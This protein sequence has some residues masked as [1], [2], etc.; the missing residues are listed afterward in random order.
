M[1]SVTSFLTIASVSL[2]S[3]LTQQVSAQTYRNSVLYH[4][5][6]NGGSGLDVEDFSQSYQVPVVHTNSV[7]SPPNG[8]T[9]SSWLNLRI[10]SGYGVLSVSAQGSA[11]RVV[12]G[13]VGR[14]GAAKLLSTNDYLAKFQDRLT[15]GSNVLPPF[16]EVTLKVSITASGNVDF[17]HINSTW[18]SGIARFYVYNHVGTNVL[19][20]A[21]PGPDRTRTMI[22]N[23]FVGAV[24][25]I[26]GTLNASC[27]A[28]AMIGPPTNT[29]FTYTANATYGITILTRGAYGTTDSGYKYPGAQSPR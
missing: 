24:V 22:V 27:E 23:T 25:P 12:V 4:M 2:A 26:A 20:L 1:R 15:I 6:A 7:S 16:S 19:D 21:H 17:S 5:T 3:C 8:V 9:G 18:A 10:G 13:G 11:T 29:W 28:D 14:G